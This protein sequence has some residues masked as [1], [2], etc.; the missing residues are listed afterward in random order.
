MII[1]S[2]AVDLTDEVLKSDFAYQLLLGVVLL[3]A[4]SSH[5]VDF[6]ASYNEGLLSLYKDIINYLTHVLGEQEVSEYSLERIGEHIP[7]T[8]VF[9][10]NCGTFAQIAMVSAW[11]LVSFCKSRKVEHL[12]RTINGYFESKD[13]ENQISQY[14]LADEVFFH[15]VNVDLG[16]TFKKIKAR[17]YYDIASVN[18]IVGSITL[19]LNPA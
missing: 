12:L 1:E 18:A 13:M 15:K 2:Y 4:Q 17:N 7:D 11:N 14:V 10:E 5:I 9:S 6:D 19:T 16:A 3:N 8:E